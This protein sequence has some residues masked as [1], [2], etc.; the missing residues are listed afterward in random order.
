MI[1]LQT[2]CNPLT[3]IRNNFCP[4]W[5]K[6]TSFRAIHWPTNLAST[7][8]NWLVQ[9]RVCKR[10]KEFVLL[11]GF[12]L[13][14]HLIFSSLSRSRRLKSNDWI[15]Q[16]RANRSWRM[17]P[18]STTS[19]SWSANREFQKRKLMW[20]TQVLYLLKMDSHILN[21]YG[22]GLVWKKSFSKRR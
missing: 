6:E 17:D 2:K 11:G 7:T 8:R 15:W 5:S 22:Q 18:M 9:S 12:L 1:L 14:V 21:F 13:K 19:S 16:R 20:A 10:K 3:L 4:F